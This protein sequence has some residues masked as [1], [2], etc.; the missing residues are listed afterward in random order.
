MNTFYKKVLK[1]LYRM[2]CTIDFFNKVIKHS[3][4]TTVRMNDS[5]FTI[6]DDG[7]VFATETFFTPDDDNATKSS[8]HLGEWA[9]SAAAGF[10]ASHHC[11]GPWCEPPSETPKTASTTERRSC[12][13]NNWTA[14]NRSGTPD[15]AADW[16]SCRVRGD[17]AANES[18]VVHLPPT[19]DSRLEA[20]QLIITRVLQRARLW[21]WRG[22]QISRARVEAELCGWT[23]RARASAD[24]VI[25][26]L[27]DN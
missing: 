11:T 16:T 27:K 3:M 26:T 15:P 18:A 14:P 20:Q 12:S 13:C 10:Y 4:P 21:R 9:L 1:S 23:E 19:A 6:V 8:G 5:H 7:N 25:G 2:F 17:C 22:V 24:P